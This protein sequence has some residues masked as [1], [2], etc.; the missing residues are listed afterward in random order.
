MSASTD[1]IPLPLP[2]LGGK[3]FLVTGGN[4]GMY[5]LSHA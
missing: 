3:V 5:V 2:D 4:A 1:L